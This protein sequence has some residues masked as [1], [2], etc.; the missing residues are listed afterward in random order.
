MGPLIGERRIGVMEGLI[1]DASEGGARLLAGGARIGNQ[2]CFFEPT[3]LADV[4]TSARIMNEEPFGPVAP[5]SRMA[6]RDEMIAEANRLSFGLA[7]YAFTERRD[8]AEM[9]RSQV[10]SGLL[11]I[12]SLLVSSPETPFG[13]IRDSGY[14]SEGG[15]EGLEAFQQT[16]LITE[17]FT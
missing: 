11:A 12:N 9:L 15:I 14:G 17:T 3:V 13:G 5:L 1:A 6:T 7:A 2:G 16:R 4:P 8:T 10:Q